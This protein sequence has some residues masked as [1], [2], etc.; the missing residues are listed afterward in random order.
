MGVW[1]C[2]VDIFDYCMHFTFIHSGTVVTGLR[3]R[4]YSHGNWLM[5]SSWNAFDSKDEE[6]KK[7]YISN[8]VC[9]EIVLS[10]FINGMDQDEKVYNCQDLH[11]RRANHVS[12]CF[13]T[14]S[15]TLCDEF[16]MRKV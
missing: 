4:L 2:T 9:F 10:L 5:C 16:L 14:N 8:K 1:T 13:W 3:C 11:V 15:N 6:V 7:A 12:K